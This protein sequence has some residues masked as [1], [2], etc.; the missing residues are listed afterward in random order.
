MTITPHPRTRAQRIVDLDVASDELTRIPDVRAGAI[1]RTALV[2]RLRTH[3]SQVVL[4]TAP[5]GYGKTTLLAQWARRDARPFAWVTADEWTDDTTL[6]QLLAAAIAPEEV[7][8][9]LAALAQGP[10]A[11]V[12]KLGRLLLAKGERNVIV[13]DRVE[14]L[15]DRRALALLATFAENLP[16]L[17]QL[18]LSGRRIPALP[19]A[20]YRI[21]G[22]LLEV[23]AAD[24]QLTE[25]EAAS[26]LHTMGIDLGDA[27]LDD[28]QSRTEGW[29]GG[30]YLS[31]LALQPLPGKRRRDPLGFS[32]AHHFVADYLEQEV[33]AQLSPE[34]ATFATEASLLDRMSGPTCDSVLDRRDSGRCLAELAELES[35]LFPLD[36]EH[37]TYRF[38]HLFR[39]ALV[40][41]LSERS[42]QRFVELSQRAADWYAEEGDIPSALRHTRAIGDRER[43]A[44]LLGTMLP[45]LC[46]GT[47]VSLASAL[48]DVDDDNILH[49]RQAAAVVGALLHALHG[50]T[51]ESD[52]WTAA[53]EAGRPEGALADGSK[54]S[55]AWVSLLHAVLARD[56]VEQMSR[57][58]ARA[59]KQLAPHSPL[60]PFA[61]L[62]LGVAHLLA[63]ERAAADAALAHA[64]ELAGSA[65]PLVT[66]TVAAELSL[67]AQ[68][69]E[70]W[71]RA[72]EL[73]RVARDA[74]EQIGDDAA[75]F[76]ALAYAASAR[77]ALRNSNWVRAGNDLQL[78]QQL[79]PRA[80]ESISWLAIQVRLEL[81]RAHLALNDIAA[82]SELVTDIDQLL[83]LRP[84]MKPAT[85]A[86]RKLQTRIASLR[87][88]ARAGSI[89]TAAELRL[90]PLLTTHLTFRQIAQHL[91]V[92][93][94]TV[95]TQSISVYRKLGVSSRTEAIDRAIEL[96]LLKP[97]GEVLVARPR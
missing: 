39:D 15:E 9:A 68:E 67:L 53:A 51:N 46:A 58:S 71:L 16:P 49:K 54:T 48:G 70:D 35:F 30:L 93:R 11:F 59:L 62:L 13:L 14:C 85:V 60:T 31:A 55:A 28:L 10:R 74:A 72:E 83:M 66:A 61:L 50:N 89:L 73:A 97:D 1:S 92:S 52:R 23:H 19:L 3:R 63:G 45:D 36:R 90:L 56:G 57:D 81:A 6:A 29:A 79:L 38:H 24:M 26:L 80:N 22:R 96:G 17:T 91:Y 82:A 76:R 5:A 33:L 88:T 25:R 27:E 34:L 42:P 65:S 75:V 44:D 18:V 64:A 21:E 86:V 20:R 84:H 7:E 95:K 47:T 37:A 32:G 87:D 12:R 78:A 41:R 94:N 2:N 69:D 4:L 43:G 8:P 77:S 40:S